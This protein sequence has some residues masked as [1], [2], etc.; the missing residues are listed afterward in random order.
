M[1]PFRLTLLS[2]TIMRIT[3]LVGCLFHLSRLSLLPPLLYPSGPL[4]RDPSTSI[5]TP[6]H[7]VRRWS[8]TRSGSPSSH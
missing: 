1:T 8:R 2:K 3:F 7:R 6:I 5:T 4:R